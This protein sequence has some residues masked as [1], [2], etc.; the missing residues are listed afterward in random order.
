MF[1]FL[2][3]QN[4]SRANG[5]HSHNYIENGPLLSGILLHSYGSHRP[6][7][8]LFSLISHDSVIPKNIEK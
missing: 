3:L 1:F 6:F 7:K 4:E 2:F 5:F 8:N